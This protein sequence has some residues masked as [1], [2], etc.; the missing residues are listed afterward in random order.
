MKQEGPSTKRHKYQKYLYDI[1]QA[2][3]SL[4]Q[5]IVDKTFEDYQND[6][7]LRSATERQ[8]AIIGEAISRL[9]EIKPQIASKINSYRHIIAFRNVLIHNY[10]EINDHTVWEII[11][12]R[13]PELEK[14]VS[15]LLKIRSQVFNLSCLFLACLNTHRLKKSSYDRKNLLDEFT[16]C[17]VGQKLKCL[18]GSIK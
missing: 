17:K 6:L 15:E 18:I 2:V 13:L 11:G 14:E 5:F 1:Q 9:A 3:N 4:E 10:A 7:M 12:H 16:C 8:L